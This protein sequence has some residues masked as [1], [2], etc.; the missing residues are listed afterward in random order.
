M[1]VLNRIEKSRHV[2]SPGH[3]YWRLTLLHEKGIDEW[4]GTLFLFRCD[5]GNTLVCRWKE[6]KWCDR[7][8]VNRRPS[9]TLDLTEEQ[10]MRRTFY[11]YHSGAV[12]RK[13]HFCIDFERFS[14][15]I[16]L[17]CRYCGETPARGLDRI[18]N[19]GDYVEENVVP[20]CKQCN[21]AKSD[22]TSEQFFTWI[23]KVY[24]HLNL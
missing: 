23:E 22:M 17:P 3:R 10:K 19:D 12:T 11:S 5:C 24:N 15:L 4:G 1:R 6:K 7:C 21:S 13:L 16:I 2:C 9:R 14:A 8:A 20:C 18:N